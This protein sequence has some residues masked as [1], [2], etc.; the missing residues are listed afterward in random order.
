MDNASYVHMVVAREYAEALNTLVCQIT[1]DGEPSPQQRWLIG[2]LQR[3]LVRELVAAYRFTPIP[4]K[5][6]R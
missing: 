3:T 6:I 4:P 2:K 5:H 1:S